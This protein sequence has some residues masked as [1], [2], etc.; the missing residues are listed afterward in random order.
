MAWSCARGGKQNSR[1][2]LRQS[3]DVF[4]YSNVDLMENGI[5]PQA[6]VK[7]RP[8]RVAVPAQAFELGAP[9]AIRQQ[10]EL[11]GLRNEVTVEMRRMNVVG[12]QFAHHFR[13]RDY[14]ETEP[15]ALFPEINLLDEGSR[16][17]KT[18]SNGAGP[19]AIDRCPNGIGNAKAEQ[20]CPR[21]G[22]IRK[23]N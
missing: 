23:R 21:S 2:L 18:I 12:A 15:L 6:P 20:G 16:G 13:A 3:L 7:G 1:L 22:N 5:R 9:I 8:H 4:E 11:R 14:F 19:L 10:P 17:E